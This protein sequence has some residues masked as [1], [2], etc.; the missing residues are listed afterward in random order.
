MPL[1][2]RKG[3]LL[4]PH[5]SPPLGCPPHPLGPRLTRMNVLGESGAGTQM[6]LLLAL[7]V[8]PKSSAFIPLWAKDLAPAGSPYRGLALYV[9]FHCLFSVFP[10]T[11]ASVPILLTGNRGCSLFKVTRILRLKPDSKDCVPRLTLWTQASLSFA[12]MK[13]MGHAAAHF[14]LRLRLRRRPPGF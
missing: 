5:R 14:C 11:T 12:E 6:L 7:A 3:P 2:C 1:Q 13:A 9:A 10:A 8:A 4:V